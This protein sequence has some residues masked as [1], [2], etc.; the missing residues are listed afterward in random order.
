MLLA[1]GSFVGNFLNSVVRVCACMR[2]LSL[3]HTLQ[4]RHSLTVS[5]SDRLDALGPTEIV[6]SSLQG[7]VLG[8]HASFFWHTCACMSGDHD[9]RL[10]CRPGPIHLLQ[11]PTP[12][13]IIISFPL[14]CVS[15]SLC[16]CCTGTDHGH[17]RAFSGCG[18]GCHPHH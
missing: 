6:L 17:L 15:S 1:V 3:S 12:F 2:L 4:T 13:C 8:A 10:V 9:A 16:R 7:D 14:L 11:I 5:A 18:A